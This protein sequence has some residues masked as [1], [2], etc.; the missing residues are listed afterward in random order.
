LDRRDRGAV[1]VCAPGDHFPDVGEGDRRQLSGDALRGNVGASGSLLLIIHVRR[2]FADGAVRPYGK[3][4]RS[5]RAVPL[6]HAAAEALEDHPARLDTPLLFPTARGT[7][8]DLHDWREDHW[9]P[10]LRAAG[11]AMCSCGHLSATHERKEGCQHERC[12]CSKFKKL[13]GYRTPY[14]MRHTFAT[15]SIAAGISLFELARFMG[16]SIEQIDAT[17]GHLLPD[18]FGRARNALDEFL[19]AA[20]S[21][22][23]T[24]AELGRG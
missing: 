4:A 16:T 24:P 6:P 1:G 10:A 15:F 9:N 8:I 3:Q 11:L 5:L 22:L 14:S 20:A 12:R 13:P 2:V 18:A 21:E 17:Y 23:D 19:S 7:L